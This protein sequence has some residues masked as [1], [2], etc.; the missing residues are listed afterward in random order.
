MEQISAP[1]RM[2][3]ILETDKNGC[4]LCQY[5]KEDS[6]ELNLILYRGD[7]NFIILNRFPYNPGHLMVAPY[8]HL[9]ILQ[10][11]TDVEA[12]EHID[13]VKKSV[14]LL[15]KVMNPHGFNVGMN[16]GKIAGAGVDDHIHTH[17]V[18]RWQG[19]T[20]FMPV[21]ADT[22]VLPESL[23]ATYK[24]LKDCMNGLL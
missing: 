17:I 2:E 9:G 15:I 11:L 21:I 19:D 20:N 4:F 6:D 14:E 12:K 8:R 18:P 1:W 5:P 24:K 3:Y 22:K 10:D 13:L 16:L 23:A 7:S